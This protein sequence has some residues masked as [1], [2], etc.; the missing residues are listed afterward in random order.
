MEGTTNYELAKMA[1]KNGLNCPFQ[2]IL[3]ADQLPT[4]RLQPRMNLIIN[5]QPTM[6]GGSH[7]TALLIRDKQAFFCDSFGA[8]PDSNILSFCKSHR[9][10][11]SHNGYSYQHIKSQACGLYCLALMFYVEHEP[12]P[13]YVRIFNDSDF[14]EKC[15]SFINL[16]EHDTNKNDAILARYL[17]LNKFA[18]R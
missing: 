17:R 11:L 8:G 6:L 15:N 12:A 4:L 10:H 1:A 9:L 5:L 13:D 3:M 2:H 16:F 14:L 7:W 18:L